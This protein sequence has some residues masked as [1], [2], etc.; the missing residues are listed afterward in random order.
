MILNKNYL[1]VYF[2]FFC[3]VILSAQEKTKDSTNIEV[4][5]EVILL[6]KVMLCL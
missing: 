2:I 5:E 3:V 4:L 1:T 6:E